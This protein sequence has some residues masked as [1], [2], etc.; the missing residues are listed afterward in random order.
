MEIRPQ[1]HMGDRPAREVLLEAYRDLEAKFGRPVE[2]G[3]FA[4]R[5]LGRPEVVGNY[6]T[7]GEDPR[8]GHEFFL[9]AEQLTA[10]LRWRSLLRGHVELG[11]LSLTRP[12]LNLVRLPNGQ[13][14]LESWLPAPQPA[15]P[16][17]PSARSPSRP[18][19]SRP[20]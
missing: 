9:R 11:T 16:G 10:S 1:N 12:S 6:V 2:V 15:S 13:W 14:N 7:V 20:C 5:I 18:R 4:I 17:G 3:N 19:S 8:F